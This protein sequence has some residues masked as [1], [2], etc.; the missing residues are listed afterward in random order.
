[1]DK[2]PPMG[3]GQCADIYMRGRETG[4]GY[5]YRHGP[6]FDISANSSHDLVVQRVIHMFAV[7]LT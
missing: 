1:M 2:R 4:V 5:I 6:H 3:M 7:M